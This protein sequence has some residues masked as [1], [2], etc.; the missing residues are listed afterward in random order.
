[1]NSSDVSESD[2]A[3]LKEL[4]K[5]GIYAPDILTYALMT[6]KDTKFFRDGKGSYLI[7]TIENFVKAW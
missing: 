2:W 1:M 5:E 6:E 3:F 7:R 4:S